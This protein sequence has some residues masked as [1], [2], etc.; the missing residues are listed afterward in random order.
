MERNISSIVKDF[1][2]LQEF[3]KMKKID[4]ILCKVFGLKESEIN[5]DLAMKDVGRWDSLTH[6]DL[7]TSLESKLHIRFEMDEIMLMKDIKSIKDITAK[8]V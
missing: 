1:Y 8:K 2:S 5:A 3:N 4:A 7:I 6:M